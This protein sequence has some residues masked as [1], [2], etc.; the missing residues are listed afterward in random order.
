MMVVCGERGEYGSNECF[1][2][3]HGAMRIGKE[4]MRANAFTF[5]FT[6]LKQTKQTNQQKQSSP[7]LLNQTVLPTLTYTHVHNMRHA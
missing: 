5:T 4:K 7:S 3:K 1:A 6:S 2:E